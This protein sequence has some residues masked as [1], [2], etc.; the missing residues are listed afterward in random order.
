MS[1]K[2]GEWIL[3]SRAS[4]NYPE[5]LEYFIASMK[6]YTAQ[7]AHDGDGYLRTELCRGTES[8][9]RQMREFVVK[10]NGG[11]IYADFR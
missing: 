4:R 1:W 6:S 2:D 3:Y 7:T 5:Y 10:S 11:R 8:E 9:V